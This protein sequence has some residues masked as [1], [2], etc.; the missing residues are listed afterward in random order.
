MRIEPQSMK[1]VG[2]W[3]LAKVEYRGRTRESDLEIRQPS[4]ELSLWRDGQVR[5]YEVYWDPDQGRA[6]LRRAR[7]GSG[8]RAVTDVTA[9]SVA[10]LSALLAGRRAVGARGARRPPRRD[11]ARTAPPSFDGRPDAVNA[12]VRL[13]EEDAVAAAER[14]DARLARAEPRRRCAACRSA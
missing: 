12:W 1:A 10:E 6:R 14:A 5:K 9:L 3:V 2:E 4:W 7:G 8:D 11:R 13:Y